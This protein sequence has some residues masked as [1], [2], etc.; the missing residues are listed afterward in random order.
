[1]V[2]QSTLYSY[3]PAG[4]E[5]AT[6]ACAASRCHGSGGRKLSELLHRYRI[7]ASLTCDITGSS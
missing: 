7:N 1:M 5:L 4:N 3:R 2:S 6:L